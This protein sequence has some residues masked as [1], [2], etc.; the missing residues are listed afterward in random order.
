MT[1]T[2][3][4]NPATTTSERFTWWACQYDGPDGRAVL[5]LQKPT[6]MEA[7]AVLKKWL[8]LP[9][10]S[11]SVVKLERRDEKTETITVCATWARGWKRVL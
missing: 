10:L 9:N 2:T 6:K 7:A 8:G 11:A 1:T 4:K 3:E 5:Q